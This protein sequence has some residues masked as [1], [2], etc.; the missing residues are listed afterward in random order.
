MLLLPL[1]ALFSLPLCLA[2]M[3]KDQ[4]H[5]E[6][7]KLAA[8]NDGIIT[9]DDRTFELLTMP[10]RDWSATVVFTALDPR[11]KCSPCKYDTHPFSMY[12]ASDA[13]IQDLPAFLRF[14]RQVLEEGAR[15][16]A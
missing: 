5:T 8:A 14:S 7:M 10:N 4:A 16:R 2:A 6:L 12:N 13:C 15:S 11:R 3:S 9:I 1:L